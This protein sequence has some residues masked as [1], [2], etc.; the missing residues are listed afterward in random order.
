[1]LNSLGLLDSTEPTYSSKA[2]TTALH[3]PDTPTPLSSRLQGR[4]WPIIS[5]LCF[6]DK[7]ILHKAVLIKKGENQVIVIEEAQSDILW[8]SLNNRL[9]IQ[10]WVC[11]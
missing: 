11:S 5:L 3:P 10:C 7:P 6:L 8:D 4:V 1:M 2:Q 9:A